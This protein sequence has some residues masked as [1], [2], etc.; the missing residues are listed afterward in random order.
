MH[1]VLSR[2]ILFLDLAWLHQLIFREIL[3]RLAFAAMCVM[4]DADPLQTHLNDT[5]TFNGY[6]K[7]TDH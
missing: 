2:L 5:A 7:P 6:Y 3:G 4:L 1:L